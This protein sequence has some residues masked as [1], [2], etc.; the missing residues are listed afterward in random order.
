ME[1][2]FYTKESGHQRMHT[3]DSTT[4]NPSTRLKVLDGFWDGWSRVLLGPL[5][6]KDH[7]SLDIPPQAEM[8]LLTMS[9]S[10]LSWWRKQ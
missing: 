3:G 1:Q 9:P 7:P 5:Q 10:E 8:R 6:R 2:A 4:A